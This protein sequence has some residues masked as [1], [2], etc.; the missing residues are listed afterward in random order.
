MR[1]AQQDFPATRLVTTV[2]VSKISS[3]YTWFLGEYFGSSQDFVDQTN[4][5]H[6]GSAVK[7]AASF[8]TNYRKLTKRSLSTHFINFLRRNERWMIGSRAGN[9]FQQS[10]FHVLFV[11]FFKRQQ[12]DNLG[13]PCYC[14]LLQTHFLE[15]CMNCWRLVVVTMS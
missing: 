9:T 12:S 8:L 5:I 1:N 13:F 11:A 10:F 2:L 4:Q 15:V 7:I 6:L 3:G 14:C